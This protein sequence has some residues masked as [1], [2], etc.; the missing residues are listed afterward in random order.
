MRT[1]I[2]IALLLSSFVA[3]AQTNQPLPVGSVPI[4]NTL[5]LAPDSTVWTGDEFGGLFVKLGKY[6][7]IDSVSKRVDS[8][9][10]TPNLFNGQG[11]NDRQR[12]QKALDLSISLRKTLTIGYNED[13]DN[14][15]WEI[16]SAI[17]VGSNASVIIRSARLKLTDSS[18]DN[19]FRSA[20]V[21]YGISAP[22]SL[23]GI[24]IKGVGVAILEGADNPRSTGDTGK[25][26]SLTPVETGNS[27]YG[28]DASVPE[29]KQTGDW[30]NIAMLF[31]YV[32]G[33]VV[34]G[35]TIR[36]VHAYAI[37]L[38]RCRNATV[39]SLVFDNPV[40]RVV[41]GDTVFCKNTD[42]V[43]VRFSGENVR[44][45]DLYGHTGDDMVAL[46]VLSTGT[47]PPGTYQTMMVTGNIYQDGDDIRNVT[48]TGVNGYTYTNLVRLLNGA[49]TRLYNVTVSSIMDI[50]GSVDSLYT[51]SHTG[52]DRSCVAIGSTI[53]STWGVPEI[54]SC[55]NVSVNGVSS[56]R[57][58]YAVK[59][60]GSLSESFIR[61]VNKQNDNG[62]QAFYIEGTSNGTRNVY[63][64]A[65]NNANDPYWYSSVSNGYSVTHLVSEEIAD[66]LSTVDLNRVMSVDSVTN[67]ALTIATNPGIGG[68]IDMFRVVNT[69]IGYGFRVN[70][71]GEF[72]HRIHAS[73]GDLLGRIIGISSGP[74]P[75]GRP[76]MQFQTYASGIDAGAG[77]ILAN[78]DSSIIFHF[79]PRGQTSLI[80]NHFMEI[81]RLDSV[82]YAPSSTVTKINAAGGNAL[83]TKAWATSVFPSLASNS[84]TGHQVISPATT[85]S[86]STEGNSIFLSRGVSGAFVRLTNDVGDV[87]AFMRAYEASGVQLTLTEGAV[88]APEYRLSALNTPPSSATDTGTTGTL[89]FGS[90]GRIYICTATN[91]WIRSEPLTTW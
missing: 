72:M 54:G 87:T 6:S 69:P 89:V 65:I 85:T 5:Y 62:I 73:T 46:T 14:T 70:N 52:G 63:L 20:N 80:G 82:I 31:G 91:T 24:E 34:E 61:E 60:G 76:M 29:E 53:S 8:L 4:S 39:Q 23:Q 27:T 9:I 37:S 48:V 26:L 10:I 43:N 30:R 57:Y 55:Y 90:D 1:I 12:I 41:A 38:E 84:F 3:G 16:D 88:L 68:D 64:D 35:L 28:T 58:H 86:P 78:M 21:G 19:I 25:T 18:R 44:V 45:A 7:E 40:K 71:R 49:G 2:L 47:R 51:P 56:Y 22:D 83:V 50:S 13:R 17:L 36:Y 66:S 11:L 67:H 81:N 77:A 32:D 79:R 42:G 74:A 59:V 33:L 15:T 75:N